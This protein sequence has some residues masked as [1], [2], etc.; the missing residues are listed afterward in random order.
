MKSISEIKD[1]RIRRGLL[2][3]SVPLAVIVFLLIVATEVG[4]VLMD[5][6][7]TIRSRIE[8][9]WCDVVWPAILAAWVGENNEE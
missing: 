7:V 8:Y 3:L 2:I 9:S 6:F 1:H 5:N 4:R